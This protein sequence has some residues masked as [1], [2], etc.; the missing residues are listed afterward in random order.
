MEEGLTERRAAAPS[1]FDPSSMFFCYKSG[2]PSS[3]KIEATGD[4]IDVEGF[5]CEMQMRYCSTLH[6]LKVH[7]ARVDASIGALG[8]EAVAL[9]EV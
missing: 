5:T 7:F 4:L 2:E 8:C 6:L 3:S 9:A 1:P